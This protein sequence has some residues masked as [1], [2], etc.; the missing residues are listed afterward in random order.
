MKRFIT[1]PLLVLLAGCG[2]SDSQE[3]QMSLRTRPPGAVCALEGGNGFAARVSTPARV[4]IPAGASP[5][6]VSCQA[7]GYRPGR[8][9]LELRG[10]GWAMLGSALSGLEDLG[11]GGLALIGID[12]GD[13]GADQEPEGYTVE[14]APVN[15][16]PLRLRQRDRT[17]DLYIIR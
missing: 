9:T 15:P 8:G 12:V 3:A 1:V 7:A 2:L 5:V 11:S 4:L 14:M 10:K 17:K 13:D 6:Q 16:Q